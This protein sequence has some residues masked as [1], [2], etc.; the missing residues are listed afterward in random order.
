MRIDVSEPRR[1]RRICKEHGL[2][3]YDSISWTWIGADAATG[4]RAAGIGRHHPA[5]TD[6][7]VNIV[8]G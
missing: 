1:R 2:A 3:P 5:K 8:S 6:V 7:T 4:C